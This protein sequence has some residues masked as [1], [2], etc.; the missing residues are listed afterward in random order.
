MAWRQALGNFIRSG[1]VISLIGGVTASGSYVMYKDF[2]RYHRMLHVYSTGNILAPLAENHYE[3]SYFHRHD[4][5]KTLEDVLN[6]NFSNEYYLI[7]GEVGTG[8]TRLIVELVREMM[9]QSGMKK[10][11]APV[12]VAVSQGKSFPETL[13]SAVEFFY[14]EHVSYQ[15]FLDFVMRINSFPRRDENSKLTRVLNA[16]EESSF[17]YLQLTGRPVVL[18]IDGANTLLNHMPGAL[19]KIQDKAKL[20]ADTNTVKVIFVNN[21]EETEQL[22]HKNASSWSRAATPLIVDDLPEEEART[23][24]TTPPFLET[25]HSAANKKTMTQEQAAQVVELVGGRMVHLVAFKRDV[26]LGK[27]IEETMEQLKDRE[28]EKFVQVSRNPSTWLVVSALRKSPNKRLKLSKAIK[29]T[30]QQ[31][32]TALAKQNI[33]RFE[34]DAVG[35]L[36]KFQSKLTEKVVEELERSYVEDKARRQLMES[37]NQTQSDKA[38]L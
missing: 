4:L 27:S 16:I 1:T 31:D 24:L 38:K 17:Q 13:A 22:L 8:K 33:I 29:E 14:D 2:S 9:N 19:E 11:G 6:T 34:R 23:F 28:R 36:I 32:I 15:F 26:V 21:D 20:W 7:N 18:I 35:A 37:K 25:S 30:S 10:L 12:Y 5:E 3:I